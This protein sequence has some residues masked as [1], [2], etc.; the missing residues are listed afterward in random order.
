MSLHHS[1]ESSHFRNPWKIFSFPWLYLLVLLNTAYFCLGHSWQLYQWLQAPHL[2]WLCSIALHRVLQTEGLG[3][4]WV[5]QVCGHCFPNSIGSLHVSGSHF[6]NSY[7]ISNFF[8]I[9]IIIWWW[10]VISSLWYYYYTRIVTCWRLRW[11]L[12]FFSSKVFLPL[13]YVYCFV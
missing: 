9:I 3:Q 1:R 6:G 13:R 2:I 5:E 8:I 7:I 10:S 12:A 11:W 4:P